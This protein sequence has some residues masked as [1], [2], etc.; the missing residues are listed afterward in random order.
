M[1]TLSKSEEGNAGGTVHGWFLH[2]YIH[3]EVGVLM[4]LQFL[5][6]IVTVKR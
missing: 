1:Q 3:W 6:V 2:T 5:S 4:V